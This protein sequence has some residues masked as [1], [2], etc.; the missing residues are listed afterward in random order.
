MLNTIDLFVGCGGLSEGFEQSRKYKMI[1]AVEWE[2][3]PVKELRNHL[4][5]RW[6]IQDSDDRTP[7]STHRS[8][9]HPVPDCDRTIW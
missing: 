8:L 1:G 9:H 6:G 2:P 3:S 7:A 5:N 4:K